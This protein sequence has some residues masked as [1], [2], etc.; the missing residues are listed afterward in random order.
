MEFRLFDPPLAGKRGVS[1]T[2]RMQG[3]VVKGFLLASVASIGIFVGMTVMFRWKA[4]SPRVRMSMRIYGSAL[5]ILVIVFSLTPSDLGFLPG[6]FI[7]MPAWLDLLGSV[8]ALSASFFGGWLQLYNLA[9]R[10]YSLR[11][12]IDTLYSTDRTTTASQVV[13]TYADGRG[14]AWMYDTRMDG[15]LR[16]KFVI[17]RDGVVS[18]TERGWR[19]ARFFRFLRRVYM[20]EE[21]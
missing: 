18:L 17:E 15:L 5:V 19:I 20:I 1:A 16:G 14:L 3:F 4:D 13:D 7:G 21:A 10:G 12:L 8:F 2:S 11:I 6:S 9:S